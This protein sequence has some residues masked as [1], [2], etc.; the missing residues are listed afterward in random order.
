MG[1]RLKKSVLKR[2]QLL[3]QP[4][5]FWLA[6][7]SRMQNQFGIFFPVNFDKGEIS[8]NEIPTVG[9]IKF[10]QSRVLFW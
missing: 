10:Y 9:Y 8:V 7:I 4:S 5:S 2:I 1:V 6:D 3:S